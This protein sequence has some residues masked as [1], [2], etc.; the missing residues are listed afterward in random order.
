MA[1]EPYDWAVRLCT[2][3]ATSTIIDDSVIKSLPSPPG[4]KVIE[5]SQKKETNTGT[6]EKRTTEINSLLASKAMQIAMAPAKSI[7]MNMIMSYMSGTSLQIIPIMAALMLLSGPIKAILGIR[8]AFKPVLGNKEIQ[9]QVNSAMILYILFQGAL[10]YIG[11]RKLNSMGLIPNTKS[12]WLSWEKHV[13]YN[14]NIKSF[15]F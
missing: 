8:S 7:P 13:D 5:K 2:E 15:V 12:D 3:A 14:K 1:C 4:F 11:L 10:M 6:D 9:S